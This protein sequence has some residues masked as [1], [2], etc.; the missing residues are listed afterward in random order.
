MAQDEGS[1]SRR[2][3]SEARLLAFVREEH[4]D[5]GG[6]LGDGGEA[7]IDHRAGGDENPLGSEAA[8]PA[9]A[10]K[11]EN[12]D[13]P[14]VNLADDLGDAVVRP[15]GFEED[16]GSV[17]EPGHES[18]VRLPGRGARDFLAGEIVEG[19]PLLDVNRALVPPGSH[20]VQDVGTGRLADGD[21][22]SALSCH[23]RE[24]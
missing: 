21:E 9:G 22:E 24:G 1:I 12:V 7:V 20:F 23:E 3:A 5:R 19:S 16:F 8:E 2:L 18:F 17:S 13:S 6:G 15:F 4:S 11:H 10:E 14:V